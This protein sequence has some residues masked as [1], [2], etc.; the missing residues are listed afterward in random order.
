MFL[1]ESELGASGPKG[2]VALACEYDEKRS[3]RTGLWMD[4]SHAQFLF[5]ADA[6]IDFISD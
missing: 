1:F 3:R 5:S 4:H 6:K 2:H